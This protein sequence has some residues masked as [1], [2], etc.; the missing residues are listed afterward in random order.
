MGS[1]LEP[2]LANFFMAN[3]EIKLMNKLQTSKSKLYL[4][5]M[6]DIFATFDDE[7]TCS[8]FFR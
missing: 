8:S 3:L 7:E 4:R 5:Q 6:D 2:A 1:P